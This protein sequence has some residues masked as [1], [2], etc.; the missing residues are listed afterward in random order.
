MRASIVFAALL[1]LAAS[2]S[3]CA[4]EPGDSYY[5]GEY[6]PP[7]P[8]PDQN[9]P[10]PGAAE[11]GPPPP[12]YYAP[13]PTRTYYRVHRHGPKWCANHPHKCAKAHGVY[14]R[15]VEMEPPAE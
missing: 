9:G 3:A 13:A 4:Y 11:Y 2:L 10:P 1:G 15:P 8:P 6:P 12:A 7:A 14:H 5:E